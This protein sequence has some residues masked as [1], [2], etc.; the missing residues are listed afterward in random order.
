MSLCFSSIF[1]SPANPDDPKRTLDIMDFPDMLA[2][3][4]AISVDRHQVG[5]IND[6]ASNH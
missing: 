6:V 3:T 4:W 5:L 2:G 1:K